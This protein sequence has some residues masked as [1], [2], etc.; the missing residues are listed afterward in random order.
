MYQARS[1]PL[2]LNPSRIKLKAAREHIERL[3]NCTSPL[4]PKYYDI[5]LIETPGPVIMLNPPKSL[6]VGL[7]TEGTNSGNVS[8]Y[9]RRCTRQPEERA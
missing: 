7:H 5:S 6:P 1:M 9:Y 4:D 3:K 2:D 8:E